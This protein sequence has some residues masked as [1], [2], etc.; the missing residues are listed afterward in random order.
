[1]SNPVDDYKRKAADSVTYFVAGLINFPTLASIIQKNWDDI[2]C[3][4]PREEENLGQTNSSNPSLWKYRM[5]KIEED[6]IIFKLYIETTKGNVL[7]QWYYRKQN[8]LDFNLK[9]METLYD[10]SIESCYL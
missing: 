2:E 9:I 10:T 1:M 7:E 3:S 6:F 4:K 8:E 5:L